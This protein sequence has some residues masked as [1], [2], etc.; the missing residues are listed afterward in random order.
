F[1]LADLAFAVHSNLPLLCGAPTG[2]TLGQSNS[3]SFL[4]SPKSKRLIARSTCLTRG[5]NISVFRIA[6]RDD[7]GRPI[8]E[9]LG[10]GFTKQG[11]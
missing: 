3:I 10:N 4:A 5:R 2:V 6:V 11:A 1:T 8:A 7:T 9:M